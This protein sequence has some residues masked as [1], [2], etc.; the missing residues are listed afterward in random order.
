MAMAKPADRLGIKKGHPLLQLE[1]ATETLKHMP[2]ASSRYKLWILCI[3]K[4]A[5]C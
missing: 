4:R 3:P 5:S 1:S 2:L